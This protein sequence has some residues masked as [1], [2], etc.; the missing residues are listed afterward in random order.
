MPSERIE[1]PASGLQDQRSATELWRRI[2]N[3]ATKRYYSNIL[4][5]QHAWITW[6]AEVFLAMQQVLQGCLVLS[7]MCNFLS[8]NFL[9]VHF[10][11]WQFPKWQLSMKKKRH[12]P[13]EGSIKCK[14]N[15]MFYIFKKI[16]QFFL[17]NTQLKNKG[18]GHK[19]VLLSGKFK[20]CL[21]ITLNCRRRLIFCMQTQNYVYYMHFLVLKEFEQKCAPALFVKKATFLIVNQC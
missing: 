14:M 20:Q 15:I 21:N 8:G 18:G 1:L 11:K 4:L 6:L 16:M 13:H 2:H 12:F 19:N 3:L 17:E 10:S 7:Q 9:I 5:L